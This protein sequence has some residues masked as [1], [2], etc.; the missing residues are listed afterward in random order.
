MS[1]VLD[2]LMSSVLPVLL[3]I[4]VGY[5]F[6]HFRTLDIRTLVDVV[7]YVAIPCLIITVI[8][9]YPPTAE[10]ALILVL[11]NFTVVGT[12]L[13]AAALLLR[14][15]LVRSRSILITSSFANAINIPVPLALYAF[16]PQVVA[17][18]VI[19]ASANMFLLYSVGAWLATGDRKG[20]KQVLTM[21]PIY[22]VLIAILL[23]GFHIQLPS[24]VLRPLE[25]LG[26]AAIPLLLFTA[27]Y[28]LARLKAGA[29]RQGIVSAG[30]RMLGGL[31]VGLLFVFLV[32][33]GRDVCAALILG[34][35]MPP[36]IQ[37]YMLCARFNTD[38]DTAASAVVIGTMAAFIVLPIL[39]PMLVTFL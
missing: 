31:S 25:I 5:A 16:G 11:G 12:V 26:N 34:S 3:V 24:L 19:F 10:D 20:W 29:L 27:G 8:G 30:L 14:L 21:P 35:A 7:I 6:A 33:P 38:P 18:Q 37:G 23:A 15:K 17:R 22:A 28:Q 2:I 36:A 13:L 32:R 4:L 9:K 1:Q 39:V